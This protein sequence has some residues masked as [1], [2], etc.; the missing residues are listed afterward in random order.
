M[1]GIAGRTGLGPVPLASGTAGA[2]VHRGPDSQREDELQGPGWG[3]S[4]IHTRLSINDPSSAGNQPL[5]NEDGSLLMIY[6]GEIYNSP[7]LRAEC[8]SAGH[9]FHSRS[10]G[11]VILHLWEMYG[12]S[13]L[14]RLNGIFAI[15][16]VDRTR[17]EVTLARD[18]LG[19]KPLFC[20]V[21]E[22]E[23]WFASELR[24][25]RAMGAPMGGLDQTALAQFLTFLWVP[26]PRTPHSGTKSLR[27]G[28]LLRWSARGVTQLSYADL[29][30]EAA[31]LEDLC[32][33]DAE[34]EVGERVGEAMRRQLLSD[35]PI[36]VMASGGIDSS[37]IW[38]NT[39]DAVTSAYTVDWSDEKGSE[40][41]QEDTETVR[42]LASAL[43]TPVTLVRGEDVDVRA[44]PASGDLF[45]DPAFHLC[46]SIAREAHRDGF[47]VLFSGQGGDE[48]FGGYRR[49]LMGPLAARGTS[50]PAGRWAAGRLA[51]LGNDSLG[52]EYAARLARATS[53]RDPLSSYMELCS[54]SNARE[55]AAVLGCSIGDV[56]DEVVW[57][58]HRRVF[59]HLPSRWSLLRRFRAVD[60][61]VYLPGLGLAYTDRASME[62][63]VEVRVPWLDLELVRWALRLP[64]RALVRGRTGKWLTRRLAAQDLPPVVAARPKRGFAVP[65]RMVQSRR[66]TPAGRGF[67][68]ASYFDNASGLL[69][70]F[71]DGFPMGANPGLI[72]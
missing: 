72:P 39:R 64:D 67:R 32:L 61:A 12:E 36:A 30:D 25:L 66:G 27:P 15:A 19:V 6:N 52:L 35:V 22:E 3:V 50:G 63:G 24:A 44:L 8:E 57:Q 46:R 43:D 34:G 53:H 70:R 62:Y 13:A 51:S 48:V 26:D 54:Y 7:E 33:G 71:V 49:H 58:E 29:C 20:V 45:A 60:L 4:L 47:K 9:L 10:D 55:R 2:L 17:G 18:P 5:S 38:S 69:E 65:A 59:D 11:E 23:L 1:C 40:G 68:Q 42:V 21:A 14:N 16:L 56:D 37:L 41:L 28:E 31:G